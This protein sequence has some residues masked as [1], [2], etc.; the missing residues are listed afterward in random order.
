M[1]EG[2]L[3][4]L[5]SRAQG[6]ENSLA[7]RILAV[8]AR[9]HDAHGLQ[10]ILG[11]A[12]LHQELGHG[13]L[14]LLDQVVVA[15]RL[16]LGQGRNCLLGH[17]RDSRP[18]HIDLLKG[19]CRQ[20]AADSRRVLLGHREREVPFQVLQRL[21]QL[22]V[23]L[24]VDRAGL[25]HVDIGLRLPL[26]PDADGSP[27]IILLATV[28]GFIHIAVSHGLQQRILALEL[29]D[30]QRL[31]ERLLLVLLIIG[32]ELA[33]DLL[34]PRKNYCPDGTSHRTSWS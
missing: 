26:R 9:S 30:R 17:L 28:N 32:R 11:G 27:G 19:L 25:V 20:V 16:H 13:G 8:L 10:N 5:R 18:C 6:A 15:N 2:V 1:E 24:V 23:G 4:Q 33:V 7:R 3:K 29:D 21:G 14:A 34:V 31:R 22:I 12:D